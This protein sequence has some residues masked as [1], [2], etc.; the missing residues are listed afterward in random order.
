MSV[1]DNNL[2]DDLYNDI[3]WFLDEFKDEN[4]IVTPR[5]GLNLRKYGRALSAR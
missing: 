3:V 4:S 1:Y 2:K 5:R